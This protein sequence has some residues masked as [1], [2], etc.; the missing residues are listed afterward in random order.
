MAFDAAAPEMPALER[1]VLRPRARGGAQR[2]PDPLER[3]SRLLGHFGLVQR[4]VYLRR[5][6][7]GQ[8]AAHR[9][10]AQAAIIPHVDRQAGAQPRRPARRRLVRHLDPHLGK[11]PGVVQLQLAAAHVGSVVHFQHDVRQRIRTHLDCVAARPRLL[12]VQVQDLVGLHD[13]LPLTAGITQQ[14]VGGPHR[15][16]R[17]APRRGDMPSQRG[18]KMDGVLVI[19][20]GRF[21]H[22]RSLGGGVPVFQAAL[23]IGDFVARYAHRAAAGKL[24]RGRRAALCRQRRRRSNGRISH[25]SYP[26]T[27]DPIRQRES[28]RRPCS[29]GG[30]ESASSL[31]P[32]RRK[33]ATSSGSANS[34][35][36]Q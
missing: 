23:A 14:Q 35:R 29:V 6:P 22:H 5:R 31:T 28:G 18:E 24:G 30:N 33:A 15:P 3:R 13:A 26:G 11:A 21:A 27:D 25:R 34:R 7:A 2:A 20:A 36:N 4:A 12:R 8:R 1:I 32:A 17:H 16:D 9:R 19:V 10:R